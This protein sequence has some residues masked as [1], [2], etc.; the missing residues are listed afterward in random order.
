MRRVCP[1][2]W[3]L[4]SPQKR[5]SYNYDLSFLRCGGGS[6]MGGWVFR[7]STPPAWMDWHLH[8]PLSGPPQLKPHT[9]CAEAP[10]EAWV[11]RRWF[12]CCP[13]YGLVSTRHFPLRPCLR[14]GGGRTLDPLDHSLFLVTV[15]V[16]V[17]GRWEYGSTSLSL[18]QTPWCSL[19]YLLCLLALPPGPV[20][21][22]ADHTLHSCSLPCHPFPV[23]AGGTPCS[24]RPVRLS[25]PGS[26]VW[27][28]T[29]FQA[30]VEDAAFCRVDT[31]ARLPLIEW[32]YW[33]YLLISE[34]DFALLRMTCLHELPPR[35]PYHTWTDM[36]HPVF[37]F[38]NFIMLH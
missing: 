22:P 15:P 36:S 34:R 5:V 13:S 14:P 24:R 8:C 28:D 19:V 32:T 3:T 6:D 12:T 2:Y 7:I 35:P 25:F 17:L 30:S 16:Q 18:A 29:S 33:T 38:Y 31:M 27:V 1:A 20:D 26:S 21:S 10:G 11:A 9:C 23:Q 4:C 37:S